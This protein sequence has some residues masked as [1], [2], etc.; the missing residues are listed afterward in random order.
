MVARAKVFPAKSVV[1]QAVVWALLLFAGFG[2]IELF[3]QTTL[4]AF[5]DKPLPFINLK[6][7][8]AVAF[9]PDGRVFVAEKKGT[10]KVFSSLSATTATTFADLRIKVYNNYD[11]GLLGLALAPQ[12]PGDAIRLR[13][14]HV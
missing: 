6:L 13:A 12:F 8:T 2:S 14:L 7:P 3:G 5:R 1:R 4:P 10:I 9:S 11:R